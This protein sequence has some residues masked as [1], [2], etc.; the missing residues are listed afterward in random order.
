MGAFCDP[1]ASSSDI[2]I[3][4]DPLGIKTIPEGLSEINLLPELPRSSPLSDLE[5]PDIKIIKVN[6]IV[7]FFTYLKILK[8]INL[9]I[10]LIHWSNFIPFIK[11]SFKA[12]VLNNKFLLIG[13]K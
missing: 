8:I 5:H 2:P 13:D 7:I 6:K 12:S 1:I 9:I 3:K 10:L 11:Y 4:K